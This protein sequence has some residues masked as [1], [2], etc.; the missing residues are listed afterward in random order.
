MGLYYHNL[1]QNV[2]GYS[3]NWTGLIIFQ[4]LD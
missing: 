2:L 1:T 3:E 4:R